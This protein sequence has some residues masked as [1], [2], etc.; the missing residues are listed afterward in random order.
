M[1][2]LQEVQEVIANEFLGGNMEIA[3]IGIYLMAVIIVFALTNRNP[4]MALIVGMA[5]TV[6]FSLM[7]ILSTELT[8]LLII[9]SVLGL[10]YSARSVWRD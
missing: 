4:Y 6:I 7:G 5:L 2:S 8:V 9:V 3:G 1:L 10:A